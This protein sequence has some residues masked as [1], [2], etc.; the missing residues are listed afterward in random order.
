M[1][2]VFVVFLVWR[3]FVR[4]S[5][6]GRAADVAQIARFLHAHKVPMIKTPVPA[7]PVSESMADEAT[8]IR[9]NACLHWIHAATKQVSEKDSRDPKD[10][11]AYPGASKA[12]DDDT[13]HRAFCLFGRLIQAEAAES[14]KSIDA[15]SDKEYRD[16]TLISFIISLKW[17][18]KM[19]R[20]ADI[21]DVLMAMDQVD[22]D[23]LTLEAVGSRK[24]RKSSESSES[25]ESSDGSSPDGSS[26]DG[27]C[28][29]FSKSF[30]DDEFSGMRASYTA[31]DGSHV[32]LGYFCDKQKALRT[33]LLHK[34][35]CLEL[36][37]W[38]HL[39]G[40]IDAI[41]GPE[42][43]R[44]LLR[45]MFSEPT[46]RHFDEKAIYDASV[47]FLSEWRHDPNRCNETVQVCAVA[48]CERAIEESEFAL[49]GKSWRAR[50]DHDV[51]PHLLDDTT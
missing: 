22:Y 17:T 8:R 6:D 11:Q 32:H 31:Y 26:P 3:A 39:R 19:T 25:F 30:D 13:I 37:A 44:D 23:G 1:Y 18:S 12:S 24:R 9:W 40:T 10:A 45:L 43:A 15:V 28:D 14:A 20:I 51:V 48:A 47:R 49:S 36:K 34:Y 21:V 7:A 2:F 41:V 16:I 27:P 35:S 29:E 46:F 50:W 38:F 5:M 42:L 4:F 33:F